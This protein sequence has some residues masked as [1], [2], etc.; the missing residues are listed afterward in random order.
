VSLC[1]FSG[2]ANISVETPSMSCSVSMNVG[3][4]VQ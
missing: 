4:S 2:E 3:G 1:T